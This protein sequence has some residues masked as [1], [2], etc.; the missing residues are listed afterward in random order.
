MGRRLR[1]LITDEYWHA[2][3]DKHNTAHYDYSGLLYLSTYGEDFQG[4]R[5][6]FID[7][8]KN[9]T[10]QPRAGRFVMFTSGASR[11]SEGTQRS[12]ETTNVF[13]FHWDRITYR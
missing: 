12:C 8:G 13:F 10:V 6:K 2:H 4:G 9:H 7:D 11:N 5:L 3:V 1:R